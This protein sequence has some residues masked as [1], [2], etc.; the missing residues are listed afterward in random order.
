MSNKQPLTLEFNGS[1]LTVIDYNGEPFVPMREFVLNLGLDWSSQRSKINNP[2]RGY[3]TVQLFL[4]TRGGFQNCTC[5]HLR[6]VTKWLWSLYP[7]R[8]KGSIRGSI[9]DQ[10]K[11]SDKSL[12]SQWREYFDSYYGRSIQALVV[13]LQGHVDFPQRE[14][15]RKLV[16]VEERCG[17]FTTSLK[18]AKAFEKDHKNV[19]QT[20]DSIV[21]SSDPD[22]S[23]LEFQPTFYVDK[24][25][26]KRRMYTMDRDGFVLLVMG[27]TGRK[28]LNWKRQFIKAFNYMERELLRQQEEKRRQ[29][30]ALPAPVSSSDSDNTMEKKIDKLTALLENMGYGD[31]LNKDD[32]GETKINLIH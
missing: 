22:S 29:Q 16:K 20:I 31:K 13:D 18:V 17:M 24:Q 2:A 10:Q 14:L 27:F 4:D 19:L 7:S 3:Q 1:K 25:G 9:V 5:L 8:V 30:L 26:K 6:H 15:Y 23:G 32:D 21:E 28:A 11:L 12:Y